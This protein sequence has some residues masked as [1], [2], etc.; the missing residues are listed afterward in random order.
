MTPDRGGP[1][2][3]GTDWAVGPLPPN[4]LDAFGRLSRQTFSPGA[5]LEAAAR[6]RERVMGAPGFD[7]S[8]VRGVV[9]DGQL[10]GGYV[11]YVRWL[12]LGAARLLTGCIGSVVT[13]PSQRRQGIARAM[14][15][16]AIDFARARRHGLLLLDG[17][18][19]LYHR[20]GY[21]DV[22]PS[23][24]YR[25][26]RAAVEALDPAGSGRIRA[27]TTED[28]AA[29]LDLYRRHFGEQAGA[30]ERDLADER[31]RLA[32]RLPL[33]PPWIVENAPGEVAGYLIVPFRERSRATEVAADDW[34]AMA[35][36]LRH[37]ANL[38]AALP[39]APLTLRWRLPPGS[40]M[41]ELLLDHLPVEERTIHHPRW[42][43]L[44]RP[45]DLDALIEGLLPAWRAAWRDR[46][47][48]ID[49]I[50]RL[51]LAVDDRRYLLELTA[52]DVQMVAGGAEVREGA[53]LPRGGDEGK[54]RE[55]AG[56]CG[57]ALG[58]A[59]TVAQIGDAVAAGETRT[60]R[61]AAT[62]L[63][64][65]AFGHR[66]L[67]WARAQ[68]GSTIDARDAAVVEA[69]FAARPFWI[70]GTDAF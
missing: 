29:M 9:R 43:W 49:P 6:W 37:H 23:M 47:R 67:A 42:G 1:A 26:E 69:L 40:A 16:D 64:R 28:A 33:N 24:E 36:A 56:P 63:L 68:P 19:D 13:E 61:L 31:H 10:V 70:P 46:R 62:T 55:D 21:V 7:P 39:D 54:D 35:V 60:I 48:G 57:D 17:I 8:Q 52:D 38:V 12:R 30:F 18:A 3:R 50:G 58:S 25:I 59:G 5:P 53:T 32:D 20:F 2:D 44:A 41:A 34:P 27:A 51:I 11:I 66:S 22:A 15:L 14:M 4:V 65:V 45:S